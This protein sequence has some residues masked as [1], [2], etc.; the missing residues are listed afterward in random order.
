MGHKAWKLESTEWRLD[1]VSLVA[2]YILLKALRKPLH[3]PP[4]LERACDRDDVNA[5]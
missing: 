1:A 4:R 3:W 5:L 2:F